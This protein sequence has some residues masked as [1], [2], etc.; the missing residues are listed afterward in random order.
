M[1]NLKPHQKS[2][3]YKKLLGV[4]VPPTAEAI[5][6][7]ES[8]RP[9]SKGLTDRLG[10]MAKTMR[11]GF[12][13]GG[14]SD[15]LLGSGVSALSNLS[16]QPMAQVGNTYQTEED[17]QEAWKKLQEQAKKRRQDGFLGQVLLPG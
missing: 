8:S 10:K 17:Y 4:D 9:E 3:V 11:G 16:Q 6:Q 14:M 12:A 15:T 13:T 1:L 7:F 2:M 5:A